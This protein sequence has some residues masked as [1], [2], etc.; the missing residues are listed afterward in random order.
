MLSGNFAKTTRFLRHLGIFYMLQICDVGQTALLPL[1]RKARWG[2]FPPEKSD[3]FGRDSHMLLEICT[4]PKQIPATLNIPVITSMSHSLPSFVTSNIQRSAMKKMCRYFQDLFKVWTLRECTASVF[5]YLNMPAASSSKRMPA[6]FQ[7]TQCHDT[8]AHNL[9]PPSR[10]L[11][12]Y[13]L[14][15]LSIF[16]FHI[17]I[18]YSVGNSVFFRSVYMRKPP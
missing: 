5:F 17:Y 10:H 3:G 11:A 18:Y 8:Q 4:S 15:Y 7:S 9:N 12:I 1:R 14:V 16:C 13:S 6:T 2:S